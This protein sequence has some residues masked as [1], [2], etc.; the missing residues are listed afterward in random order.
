MLI[1]GLKLILQRHVALVIAVRT[2]SI[3]VN[4]GIGTEVTLKALTCHWIPPC[5]DNNDAAVLQIYG[6]RLALAVEREYVTSDFKK[7]GC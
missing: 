7:G 4:G 3:S 2:L 1:I 6:Y 5:A